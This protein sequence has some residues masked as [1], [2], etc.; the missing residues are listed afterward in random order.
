M[1]EELEFK[2]LSPTSMADVLSLGQVVSASIHPLWSRMPRL[3]GPAYTVRCAPDDNLMLHAAI[4]RAPSGTVVV[5]EG[6]DTAFALAVEMFAR[7]RRSV[8]FEALFSTAR[9]VI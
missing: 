4:Y 1:D 7:W 5:V 8:E 2:D 9:S 6:G 3:A